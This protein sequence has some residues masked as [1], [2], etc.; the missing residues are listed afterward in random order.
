MKK[1]AKIGIGLAVISVVSLAAVNPVFADVRP[2]YIETTGTVVS[3]NSTNSIDEQA[4]VVDDKIEEYKDDNGFDETSIACPDF[5]KSPNFCKL[6]FDAKSLEKLCPE[7][8]PSS[9]EDADIRALA[10]EFAGKGFFLTDCKDEATMHA[11]GTGGQ[12]Y[13]F[14]NGFTAV[15][16]NTG[17]NK[18]FYEI[19]KATPEEFKWFI[20]SIDDGSF[21]VSKEGSVE[22]YTFEDSLQTFTYK[23][24]SGK[25]I[26]QISTE[27]KTNSGVG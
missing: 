7:V 6:K 24:D 20:A 12:S 3:A 22:T 4:I 1:N 5:E 14:C 10:E 13:A 27:F 25:Q 17:N 23:Y 26:L 21:D 2:G 15:D 19:V 18:C 11:A 8:D 9:Y 16:D